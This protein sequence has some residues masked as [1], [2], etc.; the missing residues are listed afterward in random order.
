M[1]RRDLRK[2]PVE[3]RGEGEEVRRG[4]EICGK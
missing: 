4:E 3:R 1:V 2:I